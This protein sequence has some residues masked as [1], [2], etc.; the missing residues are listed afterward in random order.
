MTASA[1]NHPGL[2]LQAPWWACFLQHLL[3][4]VETPVRPS[5]H[6]FDF[7]HPYV[8]FQAWHA[9]HIYSF[10]HSFN[11]SVWDALIALWFP[12][13]FAYLMRQCGSHDSKRFK[14]SS[15]SHENKIK[16]PNTHQKATSRFPKHNGLE[17]PKCP[18]ETYF[19]S[20]I[21]FFSE[22][23][24]IQETVKLLREINEPEW[25]IGKIH[26]HCLARYS[27]D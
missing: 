14:K 6:V 21:Q 13:L 9:G 10:I 23:Q 19:R 18:E 4:S 5:F 24:N 1:F 12:F 8:A 15:S 7:P 17:I 3:R 27:W 22:S 25:I 16:K 11:F 2:S 26:T 20:C